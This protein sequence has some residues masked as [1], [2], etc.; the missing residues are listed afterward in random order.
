MNKEEA[1]KLITAREKGDFATMRAVWLRAGLSA[2]ALETLAKGDA[3]GSVALNRRGA[4]WA[5][6]GLGPPPLPLF[7]AAESAEPPVILPAMSMGQEVTEDY[8]HLSLSLKTHPMALLRETFAAQGFV[9]SAQ[10]KNLRDGTKA[11][12]AGIVLIRQQPGT[13]SGV[14]F[15]TLEDETGVANIVVW[16]RVF[17]QFRRELL[18]SQLMGVTGLVQRDESGYVIHLVANRLTDLSPHLH[19]LGDPVRPYADLLSR[20]DESKSVGFDRSSV[21]RSRVIPASRDFR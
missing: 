9:P 11:Q 10:L 20:A 4:L 12:V 14:I 5:A 1:E 15:V 7:A 13:A 6:K 21:P 16:P 17:Q 3:W 19:A 18:G 2:R 8:R